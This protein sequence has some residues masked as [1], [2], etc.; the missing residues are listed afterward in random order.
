MGRQGF[1][2]HL[3]DKP[4]MALSL[5]PVLRQGITSKFCN[6]TFSPSISTKD[7]FLKIGIIPFF[8]SPALIMG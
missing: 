2:A 1:G 4:L 6:P 8:E 3:L 5:I 7:L